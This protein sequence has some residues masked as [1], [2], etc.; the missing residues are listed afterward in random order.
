MKRTNV[1]AAG[2][3]ATAEAAREL[4]WLGGNAFDAAVGAVFT[5][6]IAESGLTSAGGAGYLMAAPVGSPPVVYDFFAEMPRAEMGDELDF[7][8]VDVDFGYATQEFYVGK[9][10]AGVPGNIAGLLQVQQELGQLSLAD[11]LAPSVRTASQGLEITEH[12]AQFLEILRPILTYSKAGRDLYA[13]SGELLKEGDTFRMSEFSGFLRELGQEGSEF[14]YHG[15]PAGIITEWSQGQGGLLTAADFEQYRVVKRKPLRT[16]FAGYE[17]YL[18]PPPA[19]SG[20]LIDVTLSLLE[21][22]HCRRSRSVPLA[23][24]V[25][26]FDVTNQIRSERLPVGA[27]DQ[28]Q[29]TLS[30][31][32]R[33]EE[34]IER[35]KR[36]AK[37]GSSYPE[38]SA[39]STTHISVLDAEGNSASVTTT[40]GEGCGYILPGLGFMLNN[41]LGEQD[42]NPQGFHRYLQG[43]RLSSMVAP[44]IVLHE[45]EP[46]L[47]T[48]TAGSNRIRSVI[49]QLLLWILCEGRGIKEATELPRIHLEGNLLSTEPGVSEEALCEL[50]DRYEIHRWPSLALFFGGANSATPDQGA[51]DSRR[52]GWSLEFSA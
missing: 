22:E 36:S 10:S 27:I 52:G 42:L 37:G 14:F 6:M 12:Q 2:H 24:L 49:T 1:V 18:N 44:T 3:K 26:A 35:Y 4:L 31:D 47:V 50:E 7:F 28:V 34:Y 43:Q 38:Q 29:A 23:D 8:A 9:A 11:V 32:S 5:A 46:I 16:A 30:A 21:K 40:N 51:G 33:F 13:P 48:G 45:G 15:E 41:M 25:T 39:G 20:I 19:Q 17:V